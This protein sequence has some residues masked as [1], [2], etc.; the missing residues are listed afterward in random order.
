LEEL[1]KEAKPGVG[2]LAPKIYFYHDPDRIWSVG[3]LIHPL[4]LEMTAKGTGQKDRGQ[5]G[6]VEERGYFTGCALLVPREIFEKI[7][8]FDERFFAYYED[9]DFCL[10]IHRAG[11]RL[12]LVP[13]AKLWHKVATSSGGSDSPSERYFM[14]KSSVLFFRKHIQGWRWVIVG[15]YR[16]GSAIKTTFRLVMQKKWPS[17]KAYWRGLIEGLNRETF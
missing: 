3:G 15:P 4:T 17:A 6:G 2:V 14:A 13:N 1:I 8:F 16:L 5:W 12:V 11:Y 9:M 7:G 10:R